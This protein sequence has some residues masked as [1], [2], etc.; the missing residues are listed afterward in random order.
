MNFA[1]NDSSLLLLL[2]VATKGFSSPHIDIGTH[3]SISRTYKIIL[4][5]M[6]LIYIY[7]IKRRRQ[8]C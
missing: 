2:I 3:I 4:E 8:N 7:S 5:H 1:K 6:I